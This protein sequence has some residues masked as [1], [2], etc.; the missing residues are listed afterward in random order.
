MD[1]KYFVIG[2]IVQVTKGIVKQIKILLKWV[3]TSL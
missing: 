2:S 1:L 3:L